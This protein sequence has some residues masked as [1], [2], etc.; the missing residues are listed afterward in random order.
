METS[1][2]QSQDN[3]DS[4]KSQC[5]LSS[6]ASSLARLEKMLSNQ[7]GQAKSTRTKATKSSQRRETRSSP[8]ANSNDS[9]GNIVFS[10]MTAKKK[11]TTSVFGGSSAD[12]SVQSVIFSERFAVSEPEA[13]QTANNSSAY[14]HGSSGNMEQLTKSLELYK[15]LVHQLSVC[16]PPQIFRYVDMIRI[17]EMTRAHINMLDVLEPIITD[18]NEPNAGFLP[19]G[20]SDWGKPEAEKRLQ[21]LE[22][23]LADFR[24]RCWGKGI[25]LA[26]IN[27]AIRPCYMHNVTSFLQS[28][29][30]LAE[31]VEE[32]LA[33]RGRTSQRN[34]TQAWANKRDRINDWLFQNLQASDENVSLHRSFLINGS[35]VDQDEWARQVLKYWYI[36]E[37]SAP[38]EERCCSSIGAVDSDGERHW[39]RVKLNHIWT[40]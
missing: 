3:D 38:L 2:D 29:E 34:A 6:I 33:L 39:T 7:S 17:S 4:K 10:P 31:D 14:G 28:S 15:A 21:D 30:P 24:K 25:D 35:Q 18:M 22:K 26:A 27:R 8:G 32:L 20:W 40:N 13:F 12:D 1:L 23:Q 37:A 5:S 16:L 36:D 11:P 9:A 19:K